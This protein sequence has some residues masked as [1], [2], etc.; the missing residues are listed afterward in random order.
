MRRDPNFGPVWII[1]AGGIF[2]ELMGDHA[3]AMPPFSRANIAA[4]IHA[5]KISKVLMGARGHTP[6]AIHALTDLIIQL[7]PLGDILDIVDITIN[8]IIVTASQAYAID[9]RITFSN[10]SPV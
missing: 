1:G 9:T 6:Y 3:L 10:H 8:P 7:L 5:T 2:T 4:W